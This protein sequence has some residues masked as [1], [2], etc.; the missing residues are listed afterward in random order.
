MQTLWQD[1]RY[2]VRMLAKNRSVTLVALLTLALGIGAN[3]AIF[4]VVNGVLLRPLE[5]PQPEQLVHVKEVSEKG[6]TMSVPEANFLDW[7]R[8]SRSFAGMAMHA[9]SGAV[10]V[11]NGEAT[12]VRAAVVSRG[13]FDV[14]AVRPAAGRFLGAEEHRAGAAPVAVVS[15]SFWLNQLAA[16][17][18]LSQV[19]L[20]YDDASLPVI[21]VAPP[22]FDYPQK[23]NVWVAREALLG[24]VNPNRNAH[25]FRVVARLKPGITVEQAQADVGAISRRIR[26]EFGAAKVTAVDARVIPMLGDM[27]SNVRDALMVLLGAVGLLL[28][29]ACAN[30]ANLLLA[31]ATA[32]QKEL[33]VRLALGAGRGRLARQFITE[34]LALTLAGGALGV[35]LAVWAT[36]GMLR[37]GT[38]V[39]PRI[40]SITLDKSVLGF[41]CGVSLLMAFA[42]GLIPVLRLRGTNLQD[43]TKETSRTLTSSASQNLMRNGLVVGQVALTLVLMIGSGLLARS[44][45]GLLHVNLGFE[46]SSRLTA[47]VLLPSLS[48]DDAER[49]TASFHHQLNERVAALPGVLAVGATQALPLAGGGPNGRLTFEN[50]EGSKVWPEYRVVTHGYFKAMAIPLIGGRPFEPGDGAGSPHVA[51]VS[52]KA[53]ESLWPGQSPIGQRFNWGNMDGYV[54]DWITIVGVVGDIRDYGPAEAIAPTIY[55]LAEQRPSTA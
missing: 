4:S 43:V 32:R 16:T 26:Q 52:Q 39:L 30:V 28:L 53:A 3:T 36:D 41:A 49:R 55:L 35:L 45:W 38:N 5:F 21:G 24:P 8:D 15:H 25:N 14:M 51:L 7:Q 29:I 50:K 1:A 19:R 33:A 13:F 2:A 31:Q 10:V 27:T 18:D 22:G 6:S 12:R 54:N 11:A 20:Q 23:A 47:D 42:L 9:V 48:G 40:D 37:M 46:T 17:A 34:S 44:F